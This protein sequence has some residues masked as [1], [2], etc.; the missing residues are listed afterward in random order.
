M[1]DPDTKRVHLSR[2]IAWLNKMF[3]ASEV[4]YV[5]KPIT[6][7]CDSKIEN[8]NDN[9]EKLQSDDES[10]GVNLEDIDEVSSNND[11]V[12]EEKLNEE[13]TMTRSG[14]TICRPGRYRDEFE[15]LNFEKFKFFEECQDDPLE[16]NLVGAGLREG[17]QHTGELHVLKFKDAMQSDDKDKW[18]EAVEAEFQ[19]MIDN[20]V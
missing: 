8:K 12:E 5:N 11:E 18:N 19:R 9:V 20:Q 1:W 6:S 14:R 7:I 2:D 4:D 3:F 15:G 10:D 13:V 16:F 17:I